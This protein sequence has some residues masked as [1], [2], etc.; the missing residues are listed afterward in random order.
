MGSSS[1]RIG[2]PNGSTLEEPSVVA[3][4]GDRAIAA[5]WRAWMIE[6]SREHV[7][8]LFHP[9]CG[10]APVDPPLFG[11]LLRRL[12]LRAGA[13]I[14]PHTPLVVAVPG[15]M[16]D[17]ERS[18]LLTGIGA[19]SGSDL[20]TSVLAPV[21]AAAGAALNRSEGRPCLVIDVGHHLT[22]AAVVVHGAALAAETAWTGGA[23]ARATL[24]AHLA[25]TVGLEAGPRS[26]ERALRLA[27]HPM[28]G[29][30]AVRGSD[31]SNRRSRAVLLSSDEITQVLAPVFRD[32][33][34]LARRVLDTVP[35]PICDAAKR[36]VLLTGGMA[37][38]H[39]LGRSLEE[40]L[41]INVEIAQSP[42]RSVLSG[43]R[44][45]GAA[46]RSDSHRW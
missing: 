36:R 16:G 23:E 26:L 34:D 17:D 11:E 10:G 31:P 39:G 42:T 5:G 6:G 41:D 32:I 13:Q 21:A 19:A 33:A 15:W 4:S 1:T 35:A 37:R 30:V 20:T 29:K 44:A 27:S 40:A 45:T 3:V 24:A 22:E 28:Y 25:D 43:L 14:E 12:F 7:P 38:V 9:V 2:L 46:A 8:F 18:G